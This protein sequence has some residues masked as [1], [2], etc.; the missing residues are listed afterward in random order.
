MRTRTKGIGKQTV[1]PPY[2][3]LTAYAEGG[4][5]SD[6]RRSKSCQP[7]GFF[8][9]A[10]TGMRTGCVVGNV[11]VPR[12]LAHVLNRSLPSGKTM[13]FFVRPR[14]RSSFAPLPPQW[15]Q[16]RMSTPSGPRAEGLVGGAGF[17]PAH[18]RERIYSP[19]Q[20]AVSAALPDGA[21]GSSTGG[22]S[23]Q[24]EGGRCW[25][26]GRKEGCCGPGA[27]PAPGMGCPWAFHLPGPTGNGPRNGA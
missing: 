6:R 11:P 2:P 19:P 16:V 20:L 25:A 4:R 13:C 23:G 9:G 14:T 7:F 10:A 17:E 22:R 8:L 12:Q 24:P 5:R 27:T 3:T 21:R 15:R 26:I 18:P 1:K